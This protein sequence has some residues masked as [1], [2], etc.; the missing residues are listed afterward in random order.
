MDSKRLKLLER[1]FEAEVSAGR[2]KHH[3]HMMQTRAALAET[4]VDEGLLAKCKV[5]LSGVTVEGYELT[6]L[7]RMSYCMTCEE[8]VPN[9]RINAPEGSR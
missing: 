6:H 3:L 4:L 2:N 7:G 8:E 9:K 5:H 1:A